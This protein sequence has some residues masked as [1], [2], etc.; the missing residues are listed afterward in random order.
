M[1]AL[2][3]KNLVNW[4]SLQER[5]DLFAVYRLIHLRE[6][7]KGPPP[8]CSYEEQYIKVH[9]SIEEQLEY[10]LGVIHK[11]LQQNVDRFCQEPFSL[12]MEKSSIPHPAAG[13]GVFLRG[14]AVPGSF[15][16]FH[17]GLV[18]LAKDVRKM[19]N[20]PNISKDNCYLM[21]RYDSC[22]LDAKDF[23]TDIQLPCGKRLNNPFACGHMI[24]HPPPGKGVCYVHVNQV[25]NTNCCLMVHC[26]IK[27][28]TTILLHFLH[29]CTL[30]LNVSY[31]MLAFINSWLLL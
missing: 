13:N 20:Y 30:V 15:I 17:P 3:A 18:Y 7:N 31:T 27:T 16:G 11:Q 14:S 26:L 9:R 12:I 5:L 19:L 10:Y 28:L 2:I 21:S 6:Q 1:G 23:N 24:N 4:Q 8:T 22:I 29:L 25:S